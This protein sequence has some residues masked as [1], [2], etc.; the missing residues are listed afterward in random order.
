MRIGDLIKTQVDSIVHPKGS[1]GLI[2]DAY[3]S[4]LITTEGE[5]LPVYT[6]MMQTH[7]QK[8]EARFCGS[9][10]EFAYEKI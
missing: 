1:I 6:V 7:R 8:K 9:Q 4:G 3:P 10:L 2:I 5:H